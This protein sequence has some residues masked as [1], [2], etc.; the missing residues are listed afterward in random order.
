MRLAA[1]I[2]EGEAN[3]LLTEYL[4]P[5]SRMMIHRKVRERLQTLAG[6]L[7]W[8][9]DPYLV[10]ADNGRLVWTVDG[11]TTSDA[12]P[13]SR[14]VNVP[15]MG[16]V[17]YIRNAVKA[18]V[19]AYDG[20]THLYVFAPDDPIIA[21]YQQLFPDLFLPASQMPADL[22]AHA[23]YPETMFRVQA[24]IYRTYH[25]LDPQAFYNKED[26]WDLALH[27]GGSEARPTPVDPSFVMATLPGE[28]K[29]EFLLMMPFTPRSK[30]NLIG[31]MMARCDGDKL[32]S[33]T[34]LMLSKQELIQGP[35]NIS[36]FINQDQ[37]ISKDLTLWN[38]QG[39]RVLRGQILVLPVGE[40]FLYVQP[41]YIQA[42][43]GSMP[44]LKK[45]VLA[46]GNRLIYADTYEQAL[47]QLSS[48]AA[49]PVVEAATPVTTTSTP[50]PPAG[51]D[52]RLQSVR[53]HLRRY[54]ELASQGKFAEAGKELEALEAAA[55]Q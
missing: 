8:D 52:A 35:M 46:T 6:F 50:S 17:N 12:H 31:V 34:V 41:I 43:E 30:N 9:D 45:V 14:S 1:A 27:A 7:E 44:Q 4:A 55:K 5:N 48:G 23:R 26:V 10:I 32:G 53:E 11:Y 21:S 15:E 42:S 33:V 54:R 36:A 2:H 24:E 28:S 38:Q 13:Y 49:R 20:D 40:T 18:T 19:D 25:M 47:A 39:S 37:N 16:R 29:P 3:I 22:R 51:A